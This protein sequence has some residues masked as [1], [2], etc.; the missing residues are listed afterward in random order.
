ML[1]INT[2][3]YMCTHTYISMYLPEGNSQNKLWTISSGFFWVVKCI[4]SEETVAFFND[5][6]SATNSVLYNN[7]YE[8]SESV[9]FCNI[10]SLLANIWLMMSN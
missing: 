7:S 10:K 8:I 4:T 3:A 1:G 9:T 5:P 2:D 6:V